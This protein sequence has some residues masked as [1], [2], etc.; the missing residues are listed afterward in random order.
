MS[1]RSVPSIKYITKSERRR[2]IRDLKRAKQSA[3][4]NPKPLKEAKKPKRRRSGVMGK[5][6]QSYHPMREID[7]FFH[8]LSPRGKE[9]ALRLKFG[10]P[11]KHGSSESLRAYPRGLPGT[12]R[13]SGMSRPELLARIRDLKRFEGVAQ[14]V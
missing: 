8:R 9:T 3:A 6:G 5:I 11:R 4:Q 13:A 1:H 7:E 12:G 10:P 2:R 14:Y